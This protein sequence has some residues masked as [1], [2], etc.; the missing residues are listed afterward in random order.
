MRFVGARVRR[1]LSH[2]PGV[3]DD[4]AVADPRA[5]CGLSNHEFPLATVIGDVAGGERKGHVKFVP[6]SN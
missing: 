3:G 4:G 2:D 6:E 5:P 1:D